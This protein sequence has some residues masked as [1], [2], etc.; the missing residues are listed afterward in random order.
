MPSISSRSV[1]AS[2]SQ[3]SVGEALAA[4]VVLVDPGP[5]LLRAH[6]RKREQEVAHV[7]L[8]IED[9]RRDAG[10]E[11]FLQQDDREPGLARS[12]HADDHAVRR[13]VGRLD[14][15]RVRAGLARLWI[16]TESQPQVGHGDR[17]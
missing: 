16:E 7:S 13:Q 12:G 17:V 15:Q 8:G 3:E 6:A 4:C 11:R 5:E 14:R 9:Q 2:V 10:E 1:S